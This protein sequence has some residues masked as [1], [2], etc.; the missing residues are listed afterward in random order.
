MYKFCYSD[1]SAKTN[2][3]ILLCALLNIL[4]NFSPSNFST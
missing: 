2:K 3:A 1:A 4:F